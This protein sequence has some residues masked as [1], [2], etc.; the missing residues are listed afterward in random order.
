MK[1]VIPGII[2]VLF[3]LFSCDFRTQKTTESNH[4][5]NENINDSFS[6][7]KE[8]IN[9][10]QTS[11]SVL[12]NRDKQNYGIVDDLFNQK[13][14]GMVIY[15][16]NETDPYKKYVF[17]FSNACYGSDLASLTIDKG[18]NKL[19]IYSYWNSFPPE[20]KSDYISLN[21]TDYKLIKHGVSIVLASGVKLLFTKHKEVPLY[22]LSIVGKLDMKATKDPNGGVFKINSIFITESNMKEFPADYDCGDF[23]G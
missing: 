7:S 2:V 9:N 16:E 6:N 12:T 10:I 8:S 4:K 1:T 22:N 13:L 5:K 23:E 21:I 20:N 14:I 18:N 17:D 3:M 15:D 11:D 19:F